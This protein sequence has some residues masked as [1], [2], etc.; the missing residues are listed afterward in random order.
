MNR[1]SRRLGLLGRQVENATSLQGTYRCGNE[2][3]ISSTIE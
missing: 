1:A 2:A 3:E